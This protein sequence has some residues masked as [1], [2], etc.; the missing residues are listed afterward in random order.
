M[1][2]AKSKAK[3]KKLDI[4]AIGAGALVCEIRDVVVEFYHNGKTESVD[5]R[6]K[7]LPFAK[8]EDLHRRL[9]KGD[10]GVIAD[11][12]AMALVDENDELLFTPEQVE[13]NF[14]QALA[15]QVFS[16]VSGL[17]ELREYAE[18]LGKELALKKSSGQSLSSTGSADEQ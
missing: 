13:E 7:Q 2:K 3:E 15:N 9:N 10:K 5:I 16:E 8:T 4:K 11:W 14:T 18:N 1:A 17:K 6:I 12:I